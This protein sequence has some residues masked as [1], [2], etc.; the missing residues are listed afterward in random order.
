MNGLGIKLALAATLM[1]A[2]LLAAQETHEITVTAKK[3]QFDP[4]PIKVAKGEHVKLL[5]TAT[6]HD[7]G[8]KLEA[9]H[10]N[11]KLPKG[12]TVTVEFVADQAGTFPFECS[13]FCGLGHKRM[14][15]ELVVE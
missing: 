1:G 3:Y 14:K 10:I 4:N 15:G 7:H 2:G 5:I 6:D 8:F 12:Q 9:F 13:H 11:Q